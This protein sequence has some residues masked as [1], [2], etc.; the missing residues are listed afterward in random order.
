MVCRRNT[1]GLMTELKLS[2]MRLFRDA[3]VYL[4]ASQSVL[5]A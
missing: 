4:R 1:V 2:A 3:M 5:A